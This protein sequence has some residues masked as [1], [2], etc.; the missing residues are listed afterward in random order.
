VL[1]LLL[2]SHFQFRGSWEK[3]EIV[4]SFLHFCLLPCKVINLNV[5][6]TNM[7]RSCPFMG[8]G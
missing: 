4:C 2:C 7:G 1:L 5:I 6:P 8:R 3:R